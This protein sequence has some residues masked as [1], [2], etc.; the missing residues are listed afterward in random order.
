MT[1]S[2][3][4]LDQKLFTASSRF[5]TL[6]F[7][8]QI[9]AILEGLKRL[10]VS[11]FHHFA[12]HYRENIARFHRFLGLPSAKPNARLEGIECIL[13]DDKILI[14]VFDTIIEFIQIQVSSR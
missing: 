8:D 6:Q 12:S 9:S 2:K 3:D 5:K 11:Q 7:T 14:K 10:E 13:L 1:L 4:R